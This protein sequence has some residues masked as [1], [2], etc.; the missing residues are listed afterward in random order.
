MTAIWDWFPSPNS[1]L[2]IHLLEFCCVNANHFPIMLRQNGAGHCCSNYQW[3]R[4]IWCYYTCLCIIWAKETEKKIKLNSK[5]Y[6]I[7]ISF[8]ACVTVEVDFCM[9]E[10]NNILLQNNEK[11]IEKPPPLKT[12]EPSMLKSVNSSHWK[13]E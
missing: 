5:F 6:P 4:E 9:V 10:A 12:R 8:R 1:I 13:V 11:V 3:K 7:I 2:D